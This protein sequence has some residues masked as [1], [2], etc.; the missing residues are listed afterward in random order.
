MRSIKQISIKNCLC[1]FL[2]TINIK[3][4]DSNFLNIYKRSFK[5]TDV[6]ICNIRYIIMKSQDDVNINSG[7]SFYLIFDNVDGYT[8][9]SNGDQYFIF[10][11]TDKNKNV[12]K[13][14]TELWDEIKN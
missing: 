6:V 9:N 7:N 8:E 14:Y 13:N 10:A 2:M 12:L 11:S 4:F 3:N 5:S 1:Y